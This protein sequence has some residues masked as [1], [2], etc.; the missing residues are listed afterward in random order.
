METPFSKFVSNY[1]D[2]KKALEKEISENKRTVRPWDVINP[3]THWT[4]KEISQARMAICN[5]CPRLIK[6]T[7]QCKECGCFM[8]VKTMLEDAVCPIGKWV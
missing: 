5:E 1:A 3:N 8:S 7:K 2:E 6:F 4:I